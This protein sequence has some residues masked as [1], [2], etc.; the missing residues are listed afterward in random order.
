MMAAAALAQLLDRQEAEVRQLSLA[1][2]QLQ[3]GHEEPAAG[4]DL[5]SLQEENE[6]LRYRRLHLQRSLREERARGPAPGSS[7]PGLQWTEWPSC[8]EERLQL[9]GNLK[10]DRDSIVRMQTAQQ[11][12]AITVTLLDGFKIT[13]E[14]WRTTPYHIACQISWELEENSLVAKVNGKLWDLDRPLED[15]TRLELLTFED[16]EGR[17]VYWHS[18]AHILGEAMERYYGGSLCHGPSLQNGFCYDL[19]P[20]D[21][22]V[23]SN[24]F[25]HLENICKS[26]IMDCQAFERLEVSK[27]NLLE[28]FKYNQFKVNILNEMIDKP[29][30]VYRCGSLIDVCQGPHVRHTGRIKT[31]RIYKNS[32]ICW[33]GKSTV[34][35]LQRI[36]GISFPDSNLL[37]E[38]ERVQE[39]AN[40]WDHIKIGQEQE[41]FFFHELSPGSCFF[42]PRGAFIYN[43]LMAFIQ[44][45]YRK[46]GFTEVVSPNI[47]SSRLWEVS[48][49][50]QYYSDKM[51]TFDVEKE[52]FSLK[53]MNCPSHCLIFGHRPRSWRELPLRFA[54]FGILHHNEL[55]GA[56]TGLTRMRRFEQDGSHIFCMME[57]IQEEIK[58]C[59]DFLRSVYMVLGFT[60]QLKLSVRPEIFLGD[61]NT[62]NQ[63][64]EKL[65]CSLNAFGEPWRLSSGEGAFYGPKID[66]DVKDVLGRCHQCAAIQL[67][68][69]LPIR[70]NLTYVGKDGTD[71]NHPVI[72]H[73]TVLGSLEHMLAIL[74]ENCAGK[75]PFWLSPR[76]IM[77]VPTGPGSEEY[78]QRVCRELVEAG[79]AADVD[80]DGYSLLNQKIWKAQ[81]AQYNFILVVGDEEKERHTV[82]VHTRNNKVLGEYSLAAVLEKLRRLQQQRA[83]S[84]EKF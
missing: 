38:W 59:L 30:T 81:V 10:H 60:F 28:M 76:Q 11:R 65:K 14:S 77:L 6:R 72:I 19:F 64:E 63:A 20:G 53:P 36:Y 1:M 15:D 74:A 58:S 48:A 46:H 42:L 18:S 26:I 61:E 39:E 70:F 24:D 31:F 35:T 8:I 33:K 32:S 57:Q 49:H 17:A 78:S 54:D 9:F 84:A 23:S 22:D 41:L 47:Y 25:P 3:S 13:G 50:W 40:S 4:P 69:Q 79:F 34:E 82:K 29:T 83:P 37:K 2:E 51:F 12:K 16:P 67:D 45:E 73:F 80:L 62:W 66:V 44:M 7:G 52:T 43:T 55:S 56:L 27:E 21:R 75:W 68:F 71:E 5:R